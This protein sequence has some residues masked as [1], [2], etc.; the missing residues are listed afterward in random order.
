MSKQQYWFKHYDKDVPLNR[1][2]NALEAMES[3]TVVGIAQSPNGMTVLLAKPSD[4]KEAHPGSG[5]NDE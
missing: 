3:W 2:E 4:S 5:G 1:I